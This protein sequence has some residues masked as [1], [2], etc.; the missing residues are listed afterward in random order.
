MQLV[1]YRYFLM[2]CMYEAAVP[3]VMYLYVSDRF[4]IRFWNYFD[5]G[6]IFF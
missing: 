6:C 3:V 1:Y 2:K 5:R 4:S